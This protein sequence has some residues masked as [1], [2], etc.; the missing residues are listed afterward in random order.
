MNLRWNTIK[1]IALSE[2]LNGGGVHFAVTSPIARAPDGRKFVLT[3]V[4][5]EQPA[6]KTVITAEEYAEH[7]ASGTFLELTTEWVARPWG[8]IVSLSPE[9][10]RE[11]DTLSAHLF[12]GSE[13]EEVTAAG[14]KLLYM[15]VRDIHVLQ[16][17]LT[18]EF[19]IRIRRDLR[20]APTGDKVSDQLKQWLTF[21]RQ[22]ARDRSLK[23]VEAYILSVLALERYE[24]EQV[25][26][27]QATRL[28]GQRSARLD[29][30]DFES[31]VAV[32][33]REL[34]P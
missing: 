2:G 10:V 31:L 26:K 17:N 29:P 13:N 18:E 20:D 9:L 30:A 16:D 25:E 12:L 33:R 7:V 15:D 1:V 28:I 27:I 11:I 4:R 21:A 8:M 22:V 24:P 23:H 19:L 3:D 32:E 5:L 14:W 34:D 6:V